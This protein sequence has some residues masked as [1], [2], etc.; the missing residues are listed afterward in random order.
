[1]TAELKEP[2]TRAST[3]TATTATPDIEQIMSLRTGLV[4]NHPLNFLIG[5]DPSKLLQT[6]EYYAHT[7]YGFSAYTCNL[8]LTLQ[9]ED[10][11]EVIYDNLCDEMGLHE[12]GGPSWKNQHGELYRQFIR[13]VR[14]T[15][16]YKALG[17][18]DEIETF[19][20][21]SRVMA[22]RFYAAHAAIISEGED[23]QSL[24]AFSTIECWVSDQYAFWKRS[25][26]LL[27]EEREQLDTRTIDLHC[28]CDAEHS[29]SL[30]RLIHQKIATAGP[31]A[32]QQVKRGVA[33]GAAA[34]ERLFSDIALEIA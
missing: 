29:A 2:I 22:E 5:D 16:L 26:H 13:S 1:M 10:M 24:A 20:S 11:K 7:V 19:D 27:G 15:R 17:L 34:S 9:D 14:S 21:R 31:R 8:F 12:E 18:E 33:L 32:G 25:M 6:F 28:V 3:R 4:I 23:L 30:D